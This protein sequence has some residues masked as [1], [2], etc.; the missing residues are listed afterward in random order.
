MKSAILVKNGQNGHFCVFAPKTAQEQEV[1]KN[2]VKMRQSR[3]KMAIFG[4]F[5][6]FWGLISKQ[7]SLRDFCFRRFLGHSSRKSPN[8]GVEN[9]NIGCF[10]TPKWVFRAKGPLP[11]ESLSDWRHLGILAGEALLALKHPF[12]VQKHLTHDPNYLEILAG[13]LRGP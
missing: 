8:F 5:W 2:W 13:V 11:L 4:H 9:P 7:K 1:F 6:P 10:W 12:G 3:P